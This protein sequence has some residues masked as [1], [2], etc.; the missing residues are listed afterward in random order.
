MKQLVTPEKLISWGL[1]S[2]LLVF[3][4][5]C[6]DS[7]DTSVDVAEQFALEQANITTYLDDNNLVAETDTVYGLRYILNPQGSGSAP[8]RTDSVNVDYVGYVLGSTSSFDDGDSVVF[9][10]DDL[11]AGW[12]I[13]LPYLQEGGSMTMF[14]PSYYAYGAYAVGSIPSYSTLMFNVTLN[15]VIEASE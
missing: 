2:L 7:D 11:I 14:I 4:C 3:L 12:Q 15:E 6:I 1:S 9:Q 5:S 10:L 8:L 13:L